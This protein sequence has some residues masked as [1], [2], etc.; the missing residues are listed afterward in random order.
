MSKLVMQASF[1]AVGQTREMVDIWKN[2]KIRDKCM[3]VSPYFLIFQ[4]STIPRVSN[5]SETWLCY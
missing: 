1:R 4:M 5:I 3:V 2:P